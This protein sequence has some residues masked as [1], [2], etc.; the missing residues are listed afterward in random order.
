VETMRRGIRG[1][2]ER[3]AAF[4]DD[5]TW[6]DIVDRGYVVAGSAETVVDRLRDVV[7]NLNVGHLMVLLQFGN[8][9]REVTFENTERFAT[10]VIPKLRDH[11]GEWEDKWWPTDTISPLANER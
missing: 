11:F 2:V 9:P 8:L 6:K 10:D 5:L 4:S 7:T 1:Q 3:A